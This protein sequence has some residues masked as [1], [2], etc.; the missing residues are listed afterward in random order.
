MNQRR[1]SFLVAAGVLLC[2]GTA[3]A[4]S[5][6]EGDAGA[7]PVPIAVVV[8]GSVP[9]GPFTRE[10][11]REVGERLT[12]AGLEVLGHQGIEPLVAVLDRSIDARRAGW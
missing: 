2:A 7:I 1:R 11:S 8:K 12:G 9:E 3:G 5:P 10:L 6:G 4:G